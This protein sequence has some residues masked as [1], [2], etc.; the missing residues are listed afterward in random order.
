MRRRVVT[1]LAVLSLVLGLFVAAVWTMS[2]WSPPQPWSY[3][4]N[5]RLGGKG[6]GPAWGI[7]WSRGRIL[8]QYVYWYPAGDRN[9]GW[10]DVRIESSDW[11]LLHRQYVRVQKFPAGELQG[12]IQLDPKLPVLPHSLAWRLEVPYWLLCLPLLVF[13]I[14]V[15]CRRGSSRVSR[16]RS[17]G[18]CARCGY[19]LRATRD[20]CPE[21]GAFPTDDVPDPFAVGIKLL[22]R[23]SALVIAL[24]IVLVY[25][26]GALMTLWVRVPGVSLF[27][28]VLLPCAVAAV[29]TWYAVRGTLRLRPRQRMSAA[30]SLSPA[31]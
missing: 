21:C 9:A 5:Y 8:A 18:L 11:W 31:P 24:L 26:T 29:L 3:S 12:P 17:R 7:D 1:Y 19:D 13:P 15:R 6:A 20:R 16:R 30:S 25:E 10:I 28:H 14:W 23:L 27:W 4:R 22:L 2:W